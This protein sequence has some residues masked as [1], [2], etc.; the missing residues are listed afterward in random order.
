MRLCCIVGPAG[1]VVVSIFHPTLNP[2][3]SVHNVDRYPHCLAVLDLLGK[4][5]FRRVRA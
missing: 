2:P 4:E 1:A 5:E 3:H